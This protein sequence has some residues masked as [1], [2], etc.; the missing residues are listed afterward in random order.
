V[1]RRHIHH[2]RWFATL[3]ALVVIVVGLRVYGVDSI[4]LRITWYRLRLLSDC[5]ET[6]LTQVDRLAALGDRG[7]RHLTWCVGHDL[8]DVQ[9][10]A[11]DIL[12]DRKVKRACPVLIRALDDGTL[13][14]RAAANEALEEISGESVGF[15]P[16][17][18]WNNR[19]NEVRRWQDW[20]LLQEGGPPPSSASRVLDHLAID[21]PASG[22]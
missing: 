13:K 15:S 3:I 12:R 18:G 2:S 4:S 6:C 19:R 1:D 11:I 16:Y 7:T 21:P 17:L 10:A 22:D 5:T 8:D 9:V 14:V 20:W